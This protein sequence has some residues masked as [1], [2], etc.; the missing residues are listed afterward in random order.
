MRGPDAMSTR[1]DTRP[2][3]TGS[4]GRVELRS[5]R[6]VRFD[7]DAI[8]DHREA[9]TARVSGPVSGCRFGRNRRSSDGARAA[10]GLDVHISQSHPV[11]CRCE[12]ACLPASSQGWGSPV[13]SW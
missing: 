9:S 4:L 2:W 8:D 3:L 12:S 1:S 7:T 11:R 6:S 13:R 5:R 10:C